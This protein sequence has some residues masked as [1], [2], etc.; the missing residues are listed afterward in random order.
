MGGVRRGEENG[1]R[2]GGGRKEEGENEERHTSNQ[3]HEC[4]PSLFLYE[5]LPATH[6]SSRS[7]VVEMQLWLESGEATKLW[8]RDS[9]HTQ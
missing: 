6:T 8:R 1:K 7:L 5:L 2:E 4:S 9:I 3:E